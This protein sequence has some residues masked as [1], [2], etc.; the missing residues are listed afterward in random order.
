VVVRLLS[1]RSRPRSSEVLVACVLSGRNN[2]LEE[3]VVVAAAAVFCFW[4]CL[5]VAAVPSCSLGRQSHPRV[6]VEVEVAVAVAR[7]DRFQAD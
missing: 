4:C 1:T 2:M 3:L 5:D 6:L 7:S